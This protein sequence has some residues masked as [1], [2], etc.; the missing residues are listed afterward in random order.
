MFSNATEYFIFIEQH[1]ENCANYDD[2]IWD[3]EIPDEEWDKR[4]CPILRGLIRC[5][6]GLDEYWPK[7]KVYRNRDYSDG[8]DWICEGERKR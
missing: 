6:G 5:S 8:A 1:C 2:E 7:G 4:F 3:S